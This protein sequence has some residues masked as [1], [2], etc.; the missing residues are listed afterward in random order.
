MGELQVDFRSLIEQ[1]SMVRTAD[2]NLRWH[3]Q[4]RF[5]GR[6]H[7]RIEMGGL[8]GDVD[9]EAPSAE[10]WQ[11]FWPLLKAGEWVHVGKG[12][13]MGLGRYQMEESFA[14]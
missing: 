7:L 3:D 11:P 1:A 14:S 10:F 6:Q 4:A 9:F 13:V 5:S 8:I 2:A 12:C